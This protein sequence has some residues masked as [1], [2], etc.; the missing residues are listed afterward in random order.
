MSKIGDYR[1]RV[2]DLLF[3]N[4][5]CHYA[6]PNGKRKTINVL[7][8]GNGW[9]GN[10][11]FK[12]SFWA[13]QY[14]NSDLVIT[15]ASQNA[16][17]YQK[18]VLSGSDDA[19]LPALNQFA[20]ANGYADLRFKN[21][22]VEESASAF[23]PL[24]LAHTHYNYIIVSLGDE[25]HNWLA[26]SELIGQ[27]KAAKESGSIVYNGKILISVFNEFSSQIEQEEKEL[28]VA[29]GLEA[30]I[31]VSFFGES[32]G[33]SAE[34][35]RIARN[36]NFAY[37]MK[38]NQRTSKAHADENFDR[39][40]ESE[41]VMSP[42]DYEVE[43]LGIVRN[44]IGS[45]YAADSSFASAVHIPYK[46]A[47][48]SEY[49][50]SKPAEDVLKEAIIARNVLYKKLVALEHRRWNAYMVMRGYRAPTEAEESAL[51]FH[52][53]NTHQDKKRL[54]HIC[55]CE[56]GE[57]GPILD[58]DFK[59]QYRQ[60][61]ENKCPRKS[62]SELDRASLRCHQLTSNLAKQVN[63]KAVLSSVPK[64]S[65][66]YSNFRSSII[67]LL[68]D[69][70]NSLTLYERSLEIALSHAAAASQ[71]DYNQ[72]KAIDRTLSP[73]KIRNQRMDFISLDAQLVDM[74]PFSLWYGIKFRT[75][76]TISDGI[77]SQDV[78]IPTLF[79]AEQAI[80]IG[81]DVE[82]EEYKRIITTYFRDRGSVTTPVFAAVQH[83]NMSSI[84]D[85]LAEKLEGVDLDEVL[86]NYVPNQNA[87]VSMAL[88]R[89]IE[90][91]GGRLNVVQY[92]GNKA[93]V[94]LSGEKHLGAGLEAK[95]FSVSEFVSLIGGRV[96]NEYST[97]YDSS[98]YASIC[99]LVQNYSNVQKY[100]NS[101]GKLN[102]F[103]PWN[104]LS[105][106][107]STC[108]TDDGSWETTLSASVPEADVLQ[109][110]GRFSQFIFERCC[111]GK[112][113]QALQ[114]FHIIR[115]Y[116]ERLVGSTVIVRFEYCDAEL[117]GL[118]K[119]FELDSLTSEEDQ[120]R[121]KHMLLKF[122][123]AG[124]LRVSNYYVCD[125]QLYTS[126]NPDPVVNAEISLLWALQRKGFVEGLSFGEDGLVSFAFRDIQT[127][128][129]LKKQGSAF[130]LAVY[131]LMR[132]SGLFDDIET[133]VQIS[134]ENND[135]NVSQAL[136]QKINSDP[137][138]RLGYQYYTS[139]RKSVLKKGNYS[140]LPLENE[141]DVIAIKGM[142]PIFISCKASKDNKNEWLYEISSV[143]SHFLSTGVMAI[144]SNI[145]GQENSTFVKRAKQMDIS[146]LTAETLW[147]AGRL[148]ESL[149]KL[150]T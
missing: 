27:I 3:R 31:E 78:V 100:S 33:A 113:L 7:I 139:I 22:F 11:A 130:E 75:I 5:M 120:F 86:I 14:L 121:A 13:G 4:P 9:A 149:Q 112:T 20:K 38:Y 124:G 40:K 137:E 19:V 83:L 138:P 59:R 10:E 65:V 91:F 142:S 97:L 34:L 69:E 98:Q 89:M 82:D 92:R 44:F 115:S 52:D 94:T 48:C 90:Q 122:L 29:E 135:Q 99:E 80:Y 116:S 71:E 134:W 57:R 18:Q 66:E 28:L 129:L 141:L 45:E 125:K 103:I 24:D 67:K 148:S 145:A 21:I 123:P 64:C 126:E 136:L 106:F 93:I 42:H 26:A 49:D 43:D 131:H 96:S 73:V 15:V 110:S 88:G 61:I 114:D 105:K 128:A 102:Y 127:M 62:P 55:L 39:S 104:S 12:A 37:E 47:I 101:Q 17:E 84:L 150:I 1:L 74:I 119:G 111:I 32:T 85:L 35:E 70:E 25:E 2:Y 140:D 16:L 81:K 53:G 118:I 108:A 68:N 133:G 46:L 36:L 132:E 117:P 51:L 76:L 6:E 144:T 109:Y 72:I 107:F 143:S 41:F 30:G 8:L 95:S 23:E 77:A 60:W 63:S 58:G 147:D 146:L 87:E 56:C 79:S 54:L 50:S